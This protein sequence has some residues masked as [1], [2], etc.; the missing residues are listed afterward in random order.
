[1]ATFTP[2][3][4]RKIIPNPVALTFSGA[5]V[6]DA[7]K[8]LGNNTLLLIRN[9]GIASVDIVLK[10][11]RVASVATSG[12]RGVPIEDQ[13]ISIAAGT[14]VAFPLLTQFGDADG[15][16]TLEPDDETDI[17]YAIMMMDN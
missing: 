4:V 13:T 10:A 11:G 9:T 14:T 1:M 16:I 7:F 3:R 5:A 17:E 6:S 8:V 12:T 15:E 2:Q